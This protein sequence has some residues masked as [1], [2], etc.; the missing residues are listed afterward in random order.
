MWRRLLASLRHAAKDCRNNA[1]A[2]VSVAEILWLID[3]SSILGPT[4]RTWCSRVLKSSEQTDFTPQLSLN[5]AFW[6]LKSFVCIIFRRW[7]L[8]DPKYFQRRTYSAIS[9][10]SSD[11]VSVVW[12]VWHP[13]PKVQ[14]VVGNSWCELLPW[15]SSLKLGEYSALPDTYLFSRLALEQRLNTYREL[16]F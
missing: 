16:P 12:S 8:A 9:F 13:V 6:V 14:F 7:N 11:S 10:Q 2:I 15:L 3:R 1:V 4:D 5:R